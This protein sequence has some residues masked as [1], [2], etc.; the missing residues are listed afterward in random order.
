MHASSSGRSST[1]SYYTVYDAVVEEEEVAPDDMAGFWAWHQASS[2]SWQSSWRSNRHKQRQRTAAQEAASG[3]GGK[4]QRDEKQE[5]QQ[6]LSQL[7]EDTMAGLK[8]V[9]GPK[10][11]ELNSKEVGEGDSRWLWVWG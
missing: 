7:D 8:A 5:L 9:F 2:G 10:L 1:G 6:L 3:R 4:G 11:Q